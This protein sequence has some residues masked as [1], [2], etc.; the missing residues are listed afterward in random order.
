PRTR[1]R[2]PRRMPRQPRSRNHIDGGAASRGRSVKTGYYRR[3]LPVQPR[4]GINLPSEPL[5]VLVAP[6]VDIPCAPT[7]SLTVE[8]GRHTD[9]RAVLLALLLSPQVFDARAPIAPYLAHAASRVAAASCSAIHA[10][11]TDL[12]QTRRRGPSLK[13]AGPRPTCAHHRQVASGI[14]VSASQSLARR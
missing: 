1:R 3:R 12:R 6:T 4:L 9:S 14:P 7:H 8:L 10:K 11:I 5:G 13:L 2:L